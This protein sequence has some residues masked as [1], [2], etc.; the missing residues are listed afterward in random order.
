MFCMFILIPYGFMACIYV[1]D[2]QKNPIQ[3]ILATYNTI[4]EKISI[5]LLF[6]ISMLYA[7]PF[8]I[9]SFLTGSFLTAYLGLFNAVWF[10]FCHILI[11]VV[12][13][14]ANVE[15][16]YVESHDKTTKVIIV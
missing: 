7:L 2:Q 14:G 16:D 1:I 15:I 3:S 8:S 10:L 12:Y 11:I 13:A 4:K 5:R 9:N 6:N